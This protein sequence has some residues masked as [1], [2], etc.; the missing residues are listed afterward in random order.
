M[1]EI[2]KFLTSNILYLII[3]IV[4]VTLIAISILKKVIKLFIFSMAVVILYA[5][6][7]SYTGQQIPYTKEEIIKQTEEQFNRLKALGEN[8]LKTVIN[9]KINE[10]IK[11]FAGKNLKK[12]EE[13]NKNEK[14]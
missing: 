10:E 4:L 5:G 3:A 12:Q 2:F 6:Y 11:S 1:E 9:Q 13:E 8:K 7:L 14:K